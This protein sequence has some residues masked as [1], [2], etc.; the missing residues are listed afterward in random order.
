VAS[1]ARSKL[2]TVEEIA[3][4]L[5]AIPGSVQQLD[6]RTQNLH[7]V[8]GSSTLR[9]CAGR[10]PVGGGDIALTPAMSRFLGAPVGATVRLDAVTRQ[11]VGL[12]ENPTNLDDAFGL[13]STP[14]PGGE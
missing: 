6:L 10:Y 1:V 3:D 2:G 9:L 14:P 13:V 7:G 11:V 12:V 4:T 5:V 8:F